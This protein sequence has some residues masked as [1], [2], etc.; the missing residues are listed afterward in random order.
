MRALV[1]SIKRA[2][3]TRGVAAAA[4]AAPDS[5]PPA[6]TTLKI[7]LCQTAPGTPDKAANIA[8]AT[9]AVAD[10]AS[11]GARLVVLPEMWHCPY[12]NDSFPIHAEDV[13]GGSSPSASALAAAAK[14]GGIVLVG[15]SIA[16][17]G[18]GGAL[19]NTCL[20]FGPDGN[21][22][23]RHRKAHLF[24]VD[25]PGGVTFKES[26]TLTAGPCG[27]TTVDVSAVLGVDNLVL[28]LGI[29]YDIRFPEYASL[30]TSRGASLLIF[31]AAFNTTT[32]PAHWE[33]L[34]RGRAVD[35][36]AFVALCSPS[37]EDTG[38]GY[39][40]HGHS[41]VVDPWGNVLVDAGATAVT[42]VVAELALG[43]VA[44]RRAAM[45]LA[46]QKRGDVYRVVDVQREGGL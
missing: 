39:I 42:T 15:G 31:P 34:A 10:A 5:P 27:A 37:R 16:E 32:G 40:A 46:R 38:E 17:K 23:A 36:Q 30:L 3:S 44:K 14:A 18:P 26:D 35:G 9:A 13:D 20:V 1:S 28:G 43:D 25:I 4:T 22:L 6:A 29:C 12:G 33:L 11:K 41:L 8:A 45:P 24:D 7:A 19:Y 2:A 21:L